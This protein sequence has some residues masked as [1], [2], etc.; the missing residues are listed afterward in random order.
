M[1]Y[2]EDIKKYI[3]YNQQE[4]KDK[5]VLLKYIDDFDNILFRENEY[6]HFSASAWV[7]NKNR[8]KVLMIFHNIYNSWAWTGGHADGEDDLLDVA[9]REVKEETG[10][11]NIQPITRNAYALDIL[12]VWGH[13][14]KGKYVSAHQHLN[15]TY[16]L[17]A[18]ENE[19]LFIKQDEN[20]GVKWISVEEVTE[21]STELCMHKVYLKI[22]EKMNRKMEI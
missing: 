11:I 19:E 9:I 3:P 16:L 22:I 10:I 2:I 20:S 12:P 14:K 17:E 5:Q 1:N 21:Y 18:D 6:A 13:T 8:D 4:E 15:L 7:V